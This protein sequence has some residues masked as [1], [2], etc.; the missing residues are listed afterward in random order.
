M[1]IKDY[2]LTL[3][4]DQGLEHTISSG[5]VAA[6]AEVE[7]PFYDPAGFSYESLYEVCVRYKPYDDYIAELMT[8]GDEFDVRAAA[9]AKPWLCVWVPG[10]AYT[11][12]QLEVINFHFQRG[13][14][15][16]FGMKVLNQFGFYPNIADA[17]DRDKRAPEAFTPCITWDYTKVH[18]NLYLLL[19]NLKNRAA[20]YRQRGTPGA[21]VPSP[22]GPSGV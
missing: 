21:P 2:T 12:A 17:G 7:K 6:P 22:Q 14:K 16:W 19:S 11:E 9:E 13:A 20:Y 10:R 5:P 4:D 18:E 15:N 8:K 3:V 1:E